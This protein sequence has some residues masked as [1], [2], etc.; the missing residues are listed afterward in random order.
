MGADP[1]FT[2]I[3]KF[4]SLP[5]NTAINYDTMLNMKT[6]QWYQAWLYNTIKT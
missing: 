2:E 5:I 6:V 4:A 3:V 1:A